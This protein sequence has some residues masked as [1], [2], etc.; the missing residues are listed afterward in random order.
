MSR[1][2]VT[3]YCMHACVQIQKL[4]TLHSPALQVLLASAAAS[5]QW[6]RSAG[7]TQIHLYAPQALHRSP[8]STKDFI[9][10][11]L[12]RYSPSQSRP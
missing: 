12:A 6:S 1:H 8:P 3:I 9:Y 11:I 2:Y 7:K 4:D 5:M 10:A